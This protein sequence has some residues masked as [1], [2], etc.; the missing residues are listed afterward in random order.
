MRSIVCSSFTRE[1]ALK[2]W[3]PGFLE[4]NFFAGPYRLTLR[5]VTPTSPRVIPQLSEA[6]AHNGQ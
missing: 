3:F 6:L 1:V 4:S 5:E 2:A